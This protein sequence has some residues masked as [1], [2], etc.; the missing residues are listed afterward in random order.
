MI[1][2]EAITNDI[3]DEINRLVDGPSV[4]DYMKF[5]SV[6]ASQF[7]ATQRAVHVITRSLKSSGKVASHFTDDRWEGVI[8]YGGLSEG[9]H[10]PVDYAEYE[11]ERDGDHDFLAPARNMGNL[12]IN[13]MN[14]FL[15]G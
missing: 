2:I 13:A 10:N 3:E 11:R 6:L 8:S 14:E 12:Y 9:I 1:R 15:G 4:A 5:E 7:Q